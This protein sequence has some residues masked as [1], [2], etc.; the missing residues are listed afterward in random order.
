[1]SA[2]EVHITHDPDTKHHMV[3][4]VGKVQ[5]SLNTEEQQHLKQLFPYYKASPMNE[6]NVHRFQVNLDNGPDSPGAPALRRSLTGS[7]SPFPLSTL[8]R[9]HRLGP[10]EGRKAR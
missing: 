8:P 4:G 3:K 5:L 2:S 9:P 7:K 10:P 6:S 1:M